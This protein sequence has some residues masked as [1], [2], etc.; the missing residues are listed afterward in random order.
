VR[1]T[2]ATN[3]TYYQRIT[4]INNN[5]HQ[6]IN[7]KPTFDTENELTRLNNTA[8]QGRTVQQ[9]QLQYYT[10]SLK[11]HFNNMKNRTNIRV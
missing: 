4:T 8:L 3:S 6:K 9:I 10:V 11:E 5:R 1:Q 2:Q 7:L